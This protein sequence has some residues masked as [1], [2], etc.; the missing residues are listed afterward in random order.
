MPSTNTVIAVRVGRAQAPKGEPGGDK[1]LRDVVGPM[2]ATSG[3]ADTGELEAN[4]VVQVTQYYSP[5]QLKECRQFE[6]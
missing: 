1:F 4:D 3:A 2:N 6:I 5:A